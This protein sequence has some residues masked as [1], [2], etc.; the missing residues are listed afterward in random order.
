MLQTEQP[1][2]S[3]T[4]SKCF[5]YCCDLG[6]KVYRKQT[7]VQCYPLTLLAPAIVSFMFTCLLKKFEIKC[8]D[9]KCK[10]CSSYLTL[11]LLIIWSA[12]GSDSEHM[13]TRTHDLSK[14][15]K[16]KHTAT[17]KSALFLSCLIKFLYMEQFDFTT[18][19]G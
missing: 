3:A 14:A 17:Y 13:W 18:N 7:T 6:W 16:S 15:Y 10:S 9:A 12:A 1:S 11:K 19:L 8:V 5:H 2:H 4:Q